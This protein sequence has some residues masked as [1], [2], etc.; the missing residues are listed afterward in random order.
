MPTLAVGVFLTLIAGFTQVRT[1]VSAVGEEIVEG[2]DGF[3]IGEAADRGMSATNPRVKT[4]LADHP[5]EFVTLCVAGC[6]GKSGV[7]QILPKP[8][9]K[10]AGAMRTTA[11]G[12]A[13]GAGASSYSDAVTC[14]AGCNGPAG[15]VLQRLPGLPPPKAAPMPDAEGAGNEPLDVR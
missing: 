2:G 9:E 6:D 14:M 1:S 7:V 12:G 4:L 15:Q 13:S 5:N 8:V 3:I 10:R 11:A